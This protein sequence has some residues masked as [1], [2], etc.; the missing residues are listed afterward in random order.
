MPNPISP[1]KHSSTSA[2]LADRA[3]ELRRAM[4]PAE[5]KLWSRLRAHRFHG[6][7]IRRQHPINRFIVDF[8]YV[9][10]RVVIEL[11]GETHS[12]QIE[13]DAA[14]T[15]WLNANGY[16]VLRFT[17][18]EVMHNVEGVLEAIREACE[19]PPP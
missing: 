10:N 17:N 5:Y 7:H 11:D 19:A 16:R 3:R 15:E 12:E 1:R 14:R 2:V 9:P 13:Y 6:L 18:R 8:C 4:T